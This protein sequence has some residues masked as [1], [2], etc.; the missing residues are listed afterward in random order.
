MKNDHDLLSPVT[1]CCEAEFIKKGGLPV[2]RL[3]LMN[4]LHIQCYAGQRSIIRLTQEE[5]Q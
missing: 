4:E 2:V 1:C 5:T 3:N